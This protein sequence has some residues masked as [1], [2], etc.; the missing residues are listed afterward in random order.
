ME[1]DKEKATGE[2]RV[3][4]DAE[5]EKKKQ[6][7]VEAIEQVLRQEILAEFTETKI[8]ELKLEL[9]KEFE[10]RKNEEVKVLAEEIEQKY[11]SQYETNKEQFIQETHNRLGPEY[12]E[13][14]N[15]EIAAL[16]KQLKQ[17][18]FEENRSDIEIFKI[19]CISLGCVGI[20]LIIV[21]GGK[22]L[23]KRALDRKDRLEQDK[24]RRENEERI[25]EEEKQKEREREARRC[26]QEK[27]EAEEKIKR[28]EEARKQREKEYDA[29]RELLV[30]RY[31]S[32]LK[33]SNGDKGSV[34]MYFAEHQDMP[35]WTMH[36]EVYEEAVRRY[37]DWD[38]H[39][40]SDEE[41]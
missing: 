11:L 33:N 32:Y 15:T 2:I 40:D 26:E 18:A 29:K 35:D 13:K 28:E 7:E 21:H 8:S 24:I 25:R 17:E 16:K 3:A 4:L 30:I 36:K 34:I 38:K 37:E 19:I 22:E 1:A 20:V 12:E 10:D 5:Y 23:H 39:G 41:I 27:R 14:K 6:S 31:L 9:S